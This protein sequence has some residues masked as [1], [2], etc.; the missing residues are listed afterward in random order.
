MDAPARKP[1]RRGRTVWEYDARGNLLA[2]TLPD[3]SVVRVEYDSD[4]QP[5]CVTASGG[6]TWRYA[7]DER[8]N[9]R[10]QTTPSQAS[11]HYEY[12]QHGQLVARTAS[13][14]AVT[15][16]SYDRDGNTET[17]TD[18]LGHQTLYTHDARSNVM[19]IIS[20]LGDRIATNTIETAT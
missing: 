1:T 19:Q 11:M 4:C 5:L 2:K 16:F 13:D 10:R 15:R 9:L 14:G 18:A 3:K 6:R 12:D 17:V 20:A 7:W 8:G